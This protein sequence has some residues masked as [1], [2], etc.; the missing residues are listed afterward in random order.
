[1]THFTG[2]QLRGLNQEEDGGKFENKSLYTHDKHYITQPYNSLSSIIP[3]VSMK[4]N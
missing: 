1:M 3:C 2:L 4:D